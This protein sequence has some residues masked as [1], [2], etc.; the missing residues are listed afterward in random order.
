MVRILPTDVVLMAWAN[1]SPG[2]NIPTAVKR[3]VRT[4]QGNRC[5]VHDSTVCTG[6]L[7][8]FDHIVNVK[9]QRVDRRHANDPNGIQGLCVPCHKVKTQAESLAAR[10]RGKRPPPCHPADA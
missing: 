9:T 3:T 8:E 7:D 10:S 2:S 1:G 5:A 6:S 4:R